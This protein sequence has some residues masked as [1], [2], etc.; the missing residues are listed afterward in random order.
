MTTT[1]RSL[2]PKTS[3]KSVKSDKTEILCGIHPVR[4]ALVSGKRR[5]CEIYIAKE[6]PNRRTEPIVD[7]AKTTGVPVKSVKAEQLTQM[8]ATSAHQ[9]IAVR[10][11]PLPLTDFSELLKP[12]K[13]EAGELFLL[14]LDSVVDP[15]NLGALIRT[16]LCGGV[17]GI[18][19]PKDRSASPSPAVSRAS[20]GAMEHAPICQV[21][22][23][24]T[25]L[26]DLKKNGVWVIGL[27]HAGDRSLY[28]MEMTGPTALV[29]GGE[30]TGIRPLVRS[31]CDFLCHIPQTGPVNSLNASVAGGVAVY[32]GFRQRIA[33][34][35]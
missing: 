28:D 14:M 10:V 17:S 22:N 33:A 7:R 23:L 8:A 13:P 2:R 15:Q 11:G 1:I 12:R 20:A 16:A 25:A 26:K 24:V 6:S 5:I 31:N 3:N 9:G 18:I 19:I 27:D 32:E 34:A 35:K 4:E 30:D 29:I 21:V